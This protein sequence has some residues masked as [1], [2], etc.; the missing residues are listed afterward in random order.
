M[1]FC[2]IL[3][4]KAFRFANS[5]FKKYIWQGVF[6]LVVLLLAVLMSV[7]LVQISRYV[8]DFVL[9]P[10]TSPGDGI[11]SRALS[12]GV[13]G[14]V[15]SGTLLMWL[16]VI[17]GS[18]VVLK[19]ILQYAGGRVSQNYGNKFGNDLRLLV[20]SKMFRSGDYYSTGDIYTMLT[21]DVYQTK[22]LFQMLFPQLISFL[23]YS[24]ISLVM[25]F[26]TSWK[27]GV[28]MLASL[29]FVCVLLF[30]YMRSTKPY[31]AQIRRSVRKLSTQISSTTGNILDIKTNA[32][33][34]QALKRLREKNH[35]HFGNKKKCIT[36]SNVYQ[37]YFL[38][39]RA[40]FYGGMILFAGFLA[41]AGEITIGGFSVAV[42]YAIIM[43]DN[44]NNSAIKFYQIQEALCYAENI[45]VYVEKR[46][47]KEN[48][49]TTQEID[50]DV[51]IIVTKLCGVGDDG[52]NINKFNFVINQGEKVGFWFKD[53]KG[54]H[55][56][57]NL[58]V[59]KTEPQSGGLAIN[60]ADYKE[61]KISSIRENFSLYTPNIYLFKKSIKDNIV[62]FED[63]DE[64]KYEKI[65]DIVGLKNIEKGE[66][67][68][69]ERVI[70][71][72][73]GS[74]PVLQKQM[75]NLARTLY[76]NSKVVVLEKPMQAQK[77]DVVAD[78]IKKINGLDQ[79]TVIVVSSDVEIMKHCQKIYVVDGGEVKQ[80]STFEEIKQ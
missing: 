11:V 52:N 41:V 71:G 37:F 50:G 1:W 46:D 55:E 22:E 27:L 57:C 77:S 43:L 9:R 33:E 61:I 26:F 54:C 13:L 44:I 2:Y 76:K 7:V 8:L 36:K 63:E 80:C 48:N 16:S 62:L 78:V 66:T 29:P 19:S 3:C 17:F 30:L 51:K 34:N 15:G 6:N 23:F 75:I 21:N 39:L 68:F 14:E 24:L 79:R 49:K 73:M 69:D 47:K 32:Y 56:F 59:K 18:I 28:F 42:S 67:G 74:Y 4:M 25:I 45:R 60:G 65:I 58:L 10:T 40:L 12:D 5:H 70:R 38:L 31:F 20:L 35:V 72:Q 64:E 53:G